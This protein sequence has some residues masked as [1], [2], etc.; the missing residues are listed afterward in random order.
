MDKPEPP[1]CNHTWRR[2]RDWYGDPGVINGMCDFELWRCDLC[3]EET[4][5]PGPDDY[6]ISD[7]EYDWDE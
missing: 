3:K 7:Y 4:E 6:C 5:Q 2:T 1:T